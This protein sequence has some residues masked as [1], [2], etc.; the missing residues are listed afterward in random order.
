MANV[1]LTITFTGHCLFLHYEGE[2][3]RVVFPGGHPGA[4]EHTCGVFVDATTAV[5]FQGAHMDIPRAMGPGPL[6]PPLPPAVTRVADS[7]GL[8]D[9]FPARFRDRHP[10]PPGPAA[11][12][13]R[14]VLYGGKLEACQPMRWDFGDTMRLGT[15]QVR[16]TGKVSLQ[17]ND[18]TWPMKLIDDANVDHP[19]PLNPIPSS[20]GKIQLHFL[21]LPTSP[22]GQRKAP[23]FTAFA[24]LLQP[25]AGL[26][27]DPI[28]RDD[29]L[30]PPCFRIPEAI[31]IRGDV[32][33]LA[34]GP[35]DCLTGGGGGG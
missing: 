25:G 20:G 19:T 1:D 14:L 29:P 27:S 10:N 32:R 2:C 31:R 28:T 30:D 17:G 22:G 6:A 23:H 15:H 24:D 26:L 13:S 12:Q 21:N 4:H 16:W 5:L 8:P 33:I 34:T 9:K 35:L 11:I 18:F 3:V 7:V